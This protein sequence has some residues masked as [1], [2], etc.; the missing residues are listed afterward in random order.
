[1]RVEKLKVGLH[2][3]AV[4]FHG[5][6]MHEDNAVYGRHCADT[7]SIEVSTSAPRST[8]VESLIHEIFHVC[9]HF[10]YLWKQKNAPEEEVVSRMAFI[11]ASILV[12]N[13]WVLQFIQ[14]ER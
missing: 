5:A 9:Y 12:E 4:S 14:E 11:Y 2:T 1:M 13:P 8:Q 6:V 3:Y 7:F 10:S